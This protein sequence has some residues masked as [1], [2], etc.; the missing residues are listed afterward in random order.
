[1]IDGAR[2]FAITWLLEPIHS[3]AEKT[4][5]R[6]ELEIELVDVTLQSYTF[7]LENSEHPSS[8]QTA[9]K[10]FDTTAQTSPCLRI[11]VYGIDTTQTKDYLGAFDCYEIY[12]QAVA[13]ENTPNQSSLGY[14]VIP[15]TSFVFYPVRGGSVIKEIIYSSG[16]STSSPYSYTATSKVPDEVTH[17]SFYS[18]K[19][20]YP[21]ISRGTL[22]LSKMAHDAYD[23]PQVRVYGDGTTKVYTDTIREFTGGLRIELYDLTRN[24]ASANYD[25][26]QYFGS[27][28][29]KEEWASIPTTGNYF[30]CLNGLTFEKLV[31]I[32]VETNN[33]SSKTSVYYKKEEN[34]P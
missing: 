33:F 4:Y 9:L 5:I 28:V 27:I 26:F 16:K 29:S 6:Y 10:S 17:S 32:A 8:T 21:S 13:D 23:V 25:D 30:K 7:C 18:Y 20:G 1:M 19:D 22:K 3:S 15:V 34:K 11:H 14:I 12:H 24:D 2:Q 31:K